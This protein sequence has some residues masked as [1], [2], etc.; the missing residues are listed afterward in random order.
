MKKIDLTKIPY[1]DK[2][3]ITIIVLISI[4]LWNSIIIY[5]IKIFVVLLH[6]ISHG[7]IALLTGGTIEKI[8]I[9]FNLGG[10]C[11][12]ING[13][14]LFIAFAGYLGS[15]FWGSLLFL[16]A[17]DKNKLKYFSTFLS[18]LF[19]YFVAN[20]IS[21]IIG[22]I[23]SLFYI[24]ILFIF[25]RYFSYK[26]NKLFFA[27]VGLTSCLYVLTDIKEDIFVTEFRVTDAQLLSEYIGLS[28]FFWGTIWLLISIAVV[29]YIVRLK[30]FKIN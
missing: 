23:F 9:D 26:A 4:L 8:E 16:F 27:S 3:F 25:P 29:F 10:S 18:F 7:L 20:Y 28:P 13:N 1:F 15:L 5:P 22:I 24:V 17:F 2:I 30:L 21:G 19:L 12:I 6:E 11:N 14:Y